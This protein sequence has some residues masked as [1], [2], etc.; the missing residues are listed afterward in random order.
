MQ[1]ST[2]LA[3]RVIGGE[4]QL[5]HGG[6]PFEQDHDRILFSPAFRNLKDKTQVFP[7][8]R[9]DQI[10][11]RL[12]HSLEVA[13]VGRTLGR[14]VG[15]VLLER[16]QLGEL[17]SA[18]IGDAVSAACLMHDLGN[19]PFGHSGEKAISHWF[20]TAFAQ[21]KPGLLS[22]AG[23][24]ALND[25]GTQV[26]MDFCAF[27][28][29]AQGFRLAARRLMYPEQGGMRLTAPVLG[30]VLKYPQ[31]STDVKSRPGVAHKKFNAFRG[32]MD[33]LSQV[34]TGL[35]L[36]T[37]AEEV[38][39]RHPLAYLVEAADDICYQVLDLEDACR[40]GIVSVDQA[41]AFLT[42]LIGSESARRPGS[43]DESHLSR[44]RAKA[45]G[46]LVDA[47]VELFLDSDADLLAGKVTKPL[48][49]LLPQAPAMD[50]LGTFSFK[51]IYDHPD[52]A[53]IETTGYEILDY[54]LSRC[55]PA[56]C[57]PKP[58]H[59]L[60]KVL[61]M[62]PAMEAELEL[63]ERLHRVTDWI[64]GMTDRSA[65]RLYRSMTGMD[66]VG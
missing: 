17:E 56:I 53:A 8:P 24:A 37:V 28:G 46:T 57:E 47:T 38:W 21:E 33:L 52:V 42:P 49:D 60:Q 2:L 66:L 48:A 58:D 12:T 54:L 23:S 19:P 29:N 45:I 3:P 44:L 30:A 55:I 15:R 1:W 31:G 25:L 50:A 63:Q 61:R 9:D 32:E 6:S 18:D 11:N 13:S 36:Q 39:C 62:L 14:R 22:E 4:R 59:R 41:E 16:H 35:G 7:L 34:A 40:L 10:H 20:K 51:E 64:S 5:R 27:E 43:D 65:V 26:Q